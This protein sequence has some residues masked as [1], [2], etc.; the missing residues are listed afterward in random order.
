MDL[1]GVIVAI[2]NSVVRYS[3]YGML[4]WQISMCLPP[5]DTII[6]IWNNRIQNS[7]CIA[8]QVHSGRKLC[9]YK[10][11]RKLSKMSKKYY[12]IENRYINQ[13]KLYGC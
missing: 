10:S 1:F 6:A 4:R 12:F 9:V 5:E 13:L 8:W 2:L 11:M 7:R 3:Y